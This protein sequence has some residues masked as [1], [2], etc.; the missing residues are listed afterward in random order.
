[1]FVTDKQY[2]RDEMDIT[3][4]LVKL[5]VSN[6]PLDCSMVALELWM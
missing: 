6:F 5:E 3:R 2:M 1:M 4:L